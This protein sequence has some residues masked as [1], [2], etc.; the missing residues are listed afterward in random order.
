MD[1]LLWW[2]LWEG[3]RD[4]FFPSG[5]THP[6]LRSSLG[7][8]SY[9][10][11]MSAPI[12]RIV[13]LHHVLFVKILRRN[14]CRVSAAE[15]ISLLWNSWFVLILRTLNWQEIKLHTR[16]GLRTQC[17]LLFYQPHAWLHFVCLSLCGFHLLF[18]P[19][20]VFLVYF[21]DIW[22]PFVCFSGTGWVMINAACALIWGVW[23]QN[24]CPPPPVL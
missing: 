16:E 19:I 15:I 2:F 20:L 6:I 4:S 11:C 3:T 10:K 17:R 14:S 7:I 13:T 22:E 18:L 8:K 5:L 12:S 9:G 1:P 21:M 24:I 23:Q